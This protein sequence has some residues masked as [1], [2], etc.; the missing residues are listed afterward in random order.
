MKYLKALVVS[1]TLVLSI[2]L[3]GDVNAATLE[4]IQTISV[5][6]NT[7]SFEFKNNSEES[8][9]DICYKLYYPDGTVSESS[10]IDELDVNESNIQY[11]E[12]KG[13]DYEAE[14]QLF[15][16][17]GY[18]FTTDDPYKIGF[19][20]YFQTTHI[21]NENPES[22]VFDIED[23]NIDIFENEGE[24]NFTIVNLTSEDLNIDYK[25]ILP[26]GIKLGPNEIEKDS[27]DLKHNENQKHSIK[28]EN[29]WLSV[30]NDSDIVLS[31]DNDKNSIIKQQ[32]FFVK[33]NESNYKSNIIISV[34]IF[35]FLYLIFKCFF[36]LKSKFLN[37]FFLLFIIFIIFEIIPMRYIL[38]DTVTTGG[39]TIFH[40]I[41]AKIMR[42][43][44]L[45][46]FKIFDWYQ[47]SYAGFPLFVYYG[48]LPFILCSILDLFFKF[49]IAF[50]IATLL[51]FFLTP[52]AVYF[53]CKSFKFSNLVCFL[54]S[55]FSLLFIFNEAYSMYGGNLLSILAG[56]FGFS[57]SITLLLIFT[58]LIYK[59]VKKKKLIKINSLVLFLVGFAHPLPFIIAILL[60]TYFLLPKFHSISEIKENIIYLIKVDAIAFLLMAFWVA[61]SVLRINQTTAL[62]EL[63]PIKFREIFPSNILPFFLIALG[64]SLLAVIK[65]EK[66]IIYL[67]Y[68]IYLSVILLL[69]SDKIGLVNI[70]FIP[71]IVIYTLIIAGYGVSLVSKVIKFKYIEI[72]T[73]F[74]SLA[75]VVFTLINSVNIAPSWFKWNYS[76]IE[77][78]PFAGK[79]YE[80]MDYIKDLPGNDRIVYEH[81]NMQNNFGTNRTFESLYE[82]TN[83]PTH[84]GL[85][86]QSSATSP[87]VY[88]MQSELSEVSTHV[89]VGNEY[90][91][92][93][94]D[95]DNTIEHLLLFNVR[96]YIAVSNEVKERLEISEEFKK[97]KEFSPYVVYELVTNKNSYIEVLGDGVKNASETDWKEFSYNNFIQGD[98]GVYI[99]TDE[100]INVSSEC[101]NK[102]IE[103]TEFSNNAIKF[104]TEAIGCPHLI[105]VSYYPKW[106]VKG[107]NKI[108]QATPN[109]MVVFPDSNSVEVVYKNKLIDNISLVSSVFGWIYLIIPIK[110]S[111]KILGRMFKKDK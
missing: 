83:K 8:V 80:I 98:D 15:Y 73:L 2:Y 46:N 16:I 4:T 96:Y 106:Q 60:Q 17:Q 63:W 19:P 48:P 86:I 70:R 74:I 12:Y 93:D 32:T 13:V 54:S 47:G 89:I 97:I 104:E 18:Y 42:Y 1:L 64:A 78:K 99:N 43:E 34:V 22:D 75:F 59:G 28:I 92:F 67:M 102:E 7:L 31:F 81:S 87:F 37:V 55:L 69:I 40:Y 77:N 27:Y 6:N 35:L 14:N 49:N 36:K 5:D 66:K 57:L 110:S 23:I 88:Y 108:Y 21:V 30:G 44:F 39:D 79:F 38:Q 45:P 29:Q 82:F 68:I 58:G 9:Y 3:G 65:H 20:E 10:A 62:D 72:T 94:E 71:F 107:A 109:F 101:I 95:F 61:P 100:N 52:I 24:L 105:K 76:G 50:K 26:K 111:L 33:S 53:L 11:F 85:Y 56:E 91:D 84:E 90:S 25:I 103:V 41:A 51:G